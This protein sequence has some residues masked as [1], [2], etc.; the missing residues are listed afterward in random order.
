M[1]SVDFVVE[2]PL[3]KGNDSI[4]TVT[5]QGCTKVVI[6]VPCREDMGAEA[7][8]NLLKERV[9]PYTGIPTK[10]IS[11]W[12]ICFTSSWIKELCHALGIDQNM[13]TAYHPQMDGQSKQTN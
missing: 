13:S 2:L 6:L 4:L 8:A 9:F 1:M 10:L 11:D 7:V 5:D 12:D 3:S